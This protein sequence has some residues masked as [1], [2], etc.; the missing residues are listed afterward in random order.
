MVTKAGTRKTGATATSG[1]PSEEESSMEQQIRL[2]Q[3]IDAATEDL[4][5]L[6]K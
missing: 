2:F 4:P 1:H 3:H 6:P 5:T